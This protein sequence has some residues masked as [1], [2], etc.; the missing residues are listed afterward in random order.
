MARWM[1]LSALVLASVAVKATAET[2]EFDAVDAQEALKQAN[3]E[4]VAVKTAPF[5]PNDLFF[6]EAGSWAVAVLYM[7]CY[8]IGKWQNKRIAEKWLEDAQPHLVEQ[9]AYTGATANPPVGLLDEAKDNFKYYCTGRR[10]CSRFVG[11]LKLASRHDL[12][13]RLF[14]VI[15]PKNDYLVMP[16]L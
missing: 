3:G 6:L 14:R 1:A 16:K 11:D 7:I 5:N 9:F 15:F 10:F 12:F 2:D 4:Q 13:A 8:F